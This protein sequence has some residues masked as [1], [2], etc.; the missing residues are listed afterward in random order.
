M[1]FSRERNHTC[2]PKNLLCDG[3]R[4]KMASNRCLQGDQGSLEADIP[5]LFSVYSNCRVQAIKEGHWVQLLS[6]LGK[7]G[8]RIMIDL[9]LDHA[10]FHAVEAGRNNLY[11]LSGTLISEASNKASLPPNQIAFVRSR[12]FYGKAITNA[13]GFVCFGF[14]KRRTSLLS[15]F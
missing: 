2:P 1:L 6:L 13:R 5:G 9:F 10:I 8:E 3:F 11:Q 7:E 14:N 4:W 15:H 12:M